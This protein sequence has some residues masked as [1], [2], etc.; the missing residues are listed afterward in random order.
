MRMESH[1]L[2][3]AVVDIS[4]IYPSQ[5]ASLLSVTCKALVRVNA[6]PNIGVI[7]VPYGGLTTAWAPPYSVNETVETLVYLDAGESKYV[8]LPILPRKTGNNTFTICAFSFL[9]ANCETRS[10]FVK[11]RS[12]YFHRFSYLPRPFKI[13]LFTG[14]HVVR[15]LFLSNAIVHR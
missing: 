6:N 10:I 2:L 11:V 1:Y 14:F 7:R 15:S 9:G 3:P 5:T 13:D 4:A 8:Y 12:H